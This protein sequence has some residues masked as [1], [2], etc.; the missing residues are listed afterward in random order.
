MSGHSKWSQI[1]Y[2]KKAADLRRGNLFTK[3]SNAIAVAAR[4][5]GGD[6]Q[7]NLELR[8]AIERAKAQNMPK[9][10]IERAIKRGTG[11]L[12]GAAIEEV[13]YEAYGPGGTAIIVEAVTDNKNRTLAQIKSVLNKFGGKLAGAGAVIYLFQRQGEILVAPPSGLS[14]EE[15]ELAIIDSG[16]ND[17]QKSGENYLVY[18]EPQ[19][20]EKVK[21]QLQQAGFEIKQA[22][23][24][25][26]P[27]NP[28]EISAE[29]SQKVIQLLEA[30]EALDEVKAVHSNMA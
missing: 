8:I 18:T 24:T 25:Y 28:I 9:E 20:V 12:G 23:L 21:Q 19:E 26:E 10:N 4:K 16:A 6:P 11:E 29:D 5:G 15:A 1:K 7:T 30:L 27:Q 22:D 2:Q 13:R 17:Y 14:Q 3:L